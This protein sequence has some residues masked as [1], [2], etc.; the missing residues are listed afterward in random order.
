MTIGG[1]EPGLRTKWR[2]LLAL[3]MLMVIGA[4]GPASAET[5]RIF[6]I[7]ATQWNNATSTERPAHVFGSSDLGNLTG[8]I[9]FG[10][11][12]ASVNSRLPTP[13]PGVEW[14]DLPF[15]S[16]YPGDVRYFW[17]RLDALPDSGIE[18][19][20][21]VGANSYVVFLFRDRALFRVSW[22]LLPDKDCPSPR[23]SA[24]DLY[25]RYLAIDRSVSLAT[26]YRAGKA[27]AVEITDPNAD[28]LIPVRW[29]NRQRR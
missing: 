10:L 19:T 4:A 22:R 7:P 18:A 16:E 11:S 15:A 29:A 23:A 6:A 21:C 13:T 12:P 26:H 3:S 28:D 14:G 25:A 2:S 8:G 5:K 17:V 1:S 9:V 27:E 20:H 24:E